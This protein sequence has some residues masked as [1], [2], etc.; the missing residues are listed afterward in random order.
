[1][2]EFCE[3]AYYLQASSHLCQGDNDAAYKVMKSAAIQL[4]TPS[5]NTLK[6][7]G[8]IAVRIAPPRFM[9]AI[10]SLGSILKRNPQDFEVVSCVLRIFFC[11]VQV[12]TWKQYLG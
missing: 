6:M 9:E 3:E 12:V 5:R 4:E 11:T 10:D 8:Y 2:N 7:C 1:M